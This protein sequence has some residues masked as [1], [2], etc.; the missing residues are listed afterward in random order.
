M[1]KVEKTRFNA[2]G[3]PSSTRLFPLLGKADTKWWHET[4]IVKFDLTA[5]FFVWP[6]WEKLKKRVLNAIG[7]P[8]ST[9][10]FPLLGKA[11]TKWWHET[12]IVKFDLTAVFFVWPRWEKLKKRVLTQLED[13]RQPGFFRCLE[14]P[15]QNGGMK[16]KL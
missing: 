15:T 7:G 10:L 13:L 16:P 8:S 9:R 6:R 11:H 4:E 14:K 5:V 2:I 3:G 1:G 12:Q